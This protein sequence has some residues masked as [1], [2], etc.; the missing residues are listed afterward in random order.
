MVFIN[1]NLTPLQMKKLEKRWNDYLISR[2][3]RLRQ[4]NLKSVWKDTEL[5]PTET[6][7]TTALSDMPH[8]SDPLARKIR[9]IDRFAVIL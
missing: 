2:E 3:E 6:E 8:F 9:V 4:Y 1:A 5:T 7:N